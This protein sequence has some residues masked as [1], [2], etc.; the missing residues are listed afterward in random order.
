MRDRC[1]GAMAVVRTLVVVLLVLGSVGGERV[2][3]DT[4]ASTTASLNVG[5]TSDTTFAVAVSGST[6]SAVTYRTGSS[7]QNASGSVVITVVDARGTGAG[8]T[9]SLAASGDLK[10]GA[11]SIPINALSFQPASVQ[12]QN[13]ANP[14][15]IN[16]YALTMSA[17]SQRV[18]VATN[19]SG[20][21]T[22][23]CA[24]QGTIRVPDRTAAGTYTTTLT[25]TLVSGS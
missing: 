19:G 6:F 11:S 23:V 10:S 8:W 2:F 5:P 3:A 25:V 7:F 15:G 12:G 20:K 14:N 16:R 18:L 21:G 9:V 4:S 13:G 17:Q 24:L 22:F 1:L